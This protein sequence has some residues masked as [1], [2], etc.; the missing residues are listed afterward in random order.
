M[1]TEEEG[2]FTL[3]ATITPSVALR[4]LL[5]E[6]SSTVELLKPERLR[7]ELGALLATAA[8]RYAEKV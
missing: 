4:N 1:I 8:Q 5:L 7:A 2:G 3:R 6:R